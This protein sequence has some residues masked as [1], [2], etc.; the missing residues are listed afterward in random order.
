MAPYLL[1]GF[2]FAGILYAWF[3]ADKVYKYLG[4]KN[5][6]S[7]LNASL[8]GIPLPLC[9]CGVIPTGVSF[10][11]NGASKGASVSFLISTP[12]T[13]VDSILV[14]WSLLG[15]PLAIIRPIIALFTGLLGGLLT[16]RGEKDKI[17]ETAD[18]VAAAPIAPRKKIGVSGML[19][20][21]FVD[22]MQ[23]IVKWLTIGLI[24]AAAMAAIIPDDFFTNYLQNDYL[25]MLLVLVASIPLYVCATGSVPIAAVLIMK[26]LSPGA[27]IVFLMAGPATNAATMSVIGNTMGRKTLITYLFSIIAGAIFFGILI[28][29]IF[30]RDFFLNAM[31]HLHHENHEHGFLPYWLQAGSAIVLSILMAYGL[32]MKYIHPKFLS[33]KTIVEKSENMNEL[34]IKVDG[35]TCNHCKSNVEN[36]LRK[37]SGIKDVQI[38][39]SSGKVSIHGEKLDKAEIADTI[40]NLGYTVA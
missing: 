39:L 7:V 27:A 19:R 21:A 36:N 14:T 35:M 10:Y 9:S 12:Q 24:I 37:I 29:E 17:N 31:G 28:N 34:L 40:T 6:R 16:N 18:V 1:L 23:D 4:K 26:G 38:D 25:S 11:K 8:L 32:F 22:F 5:F 2:L 15:W 13:G 30:P 20:Y 33:K 3:P